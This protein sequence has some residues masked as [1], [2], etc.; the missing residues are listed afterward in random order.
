MESKLIEKIL[1]H[2]TIKKKSLDLYLA[3][4]RRLNG[5][6]AITN[7][8]FLKN[9]KDIKEQIK[10]YSLPTQRNY[11]SSILVVLTE[12]PNYEKTRLKYTKLLEKLNIKYQKEIDKHKKS[13]KESENWATLHELRSVVLPYYKTI[14]NKF[15]LLKELSRL[16]IETYQR[17]LVASLYHLQP[18]VRVDYDMEIVNNKREMIDK[19]TNYLLNSTRTTKYFIFRNYKTASTYGEIKVKV[20]KGLNSIINQW[21]K[22]NPT[23]FLIFDNKNNKMS[24]N[25]LAKY[26]VKSLEPS[27]KH[28]NLNLLRKIW[29]SENL[30]LNQVCSRDKLATAMM[31]SLDTQ[32]TYIKL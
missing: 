18:S 20:N 26:I 5:N 3:N 6:N 25:N 12:Q 1:N 16:D 11:I 13:D 14:I 24:K 22:I 29:I 32:K 7:L 23:N 19:N 31:H 21:L 30:D 9:I 28:I 2:R 27:G 8:V 15:K 10:D 4:E 17:Y